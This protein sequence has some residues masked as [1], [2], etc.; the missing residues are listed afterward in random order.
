MANLKYYRDEFNRYGSMGPATE[1]Q[2]NEAVRAACQKFGMIHVKLVVNPRLRTYSLYKG[3]ALLVAPNNRVAKPLVV[4]TIAMNVRHMNWQIFTHE[5]A[6]HL[7]FCRK[8]KQVE[9][10]AA[11]KNVPFAPMTRHERYVFARDNMPKEH[12]HG[13]VHRKAMQELVNF[14][15]EAGFI[16]EKPTYMLAASASA[17]VNTIAKV[18]N[19]TPERVLTDAE[20]DVLAPAAGK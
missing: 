11:E 19:T 10:K 13:P 4:P 15:M 3:G 14:F 7:H 17:A 9:A 20:L 1:A 5:L 6:H 2:M 16:T 18:L 8:T 12:A